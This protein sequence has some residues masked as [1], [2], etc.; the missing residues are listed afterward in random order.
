VRGAAAFVLCASAALAFASA[1]AGAATAEQIGQTAVFRASPGATNDLT[2]EGGGGEVDFIDASALVSPRSGCVALTPMAVRCEQP[3]SN[4]DNFSLADVHLGDGNDRAQT[5]IP[6]TNEFS[7]DL[8]VWAGPGNDDVR[9]DSFGGS[10]QVYGEAGNDRVS[11]F[12]DGDQIADG[13][14]GN[15]FV[16][17]GGTGGLQIGRGGPGNDTIDFAADLFSVAD[18]EGGPGNDKIFGNPGGLPGS[19][20]SGG[21]GN[22]L[23]VAVNQFRGDDEPGYT[24]NGDAGNDELIGG[25]FPDIVNG[26]EGNDTINVAG[27]GA[28]TVDCGSGYDTVRYDSSDTISPDCESHPRALGLSCSAHIGRAVRPATPELPLTCASPARSPGSPSAFAREPEHSRCAR[29]VAAIG[30]HAG[31]RVLRSTSAR[32]SRSPPGHACQRGPDRGQG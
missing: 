14:A 30:I 12:G 16:F 32:H 29:L 26:G 27:G 9:V 25:E 31:Q 3:D 18:L 21:P 22:D 6:P 8:R 10:T 2:I 24:L 15:D 11:A 19:T 13:G 5:A 1:P 17:T 23:V 7:G 28:D 20:A 4:G